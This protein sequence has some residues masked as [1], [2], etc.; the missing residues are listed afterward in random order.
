MIGSLRLRLM[1]AVAA[2]M[3]VVA[4]LDAWTTFRAAED[5]ARIVQER[6][7]VG[8]A[9]FIGEQVHL[10]E[11]VVQADIPPAALELFASPSRDHVFYRIASADHQTLAGYFDL[12]EP[13]QRL[14]GESVQ[15]YDTALRDRQVHAVAFEQPVFSAPQKGPVLIQIGQ[16]LDGR[17]A[18]AREIWAASI[19]GHVALLLLGVVV[20][21]FAMRLWLRPLL[22]LRD[23]FARHAP[24]ALVPLDA[25]RTPDELQPLVKVVNEYVGRLDAHMSAHE[26]FIADASHQLRTPLTV[27]NT[28]VSYAL[29]ARDGRASDMALAAIRQSVQ[30]GIR[31]VNQ[32]L[33]VDRVRARRPAALPEVDLVQTVA[34]VLDAHATHAQQ[35]GIDLGLEGG[36]ATL[37]V[38]ADPVLLFEMIS[39]LVDNAVRY[40][41]HG[42]TV[43]AKVTSRGGETLVEVVDDG[44]GIPVEARELVFQRFHRL[45]NSR[46][47]GSGLGLSIVRD[48]AGHCGAQVELDA[49]AQ[50]RGLLA[51]VRFPA[52]HDVAGAG[53]PVLLASSSG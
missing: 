5:T 13:G 43:T 11:G 33:T 16:T 38:R 20:L 14:P 29:Q 6:M 41:Q 28:Q 9:R 40:T 48:V 34:A 50:H 39:N 3:A 35:R 44:P 47:D 32:L 25:S 52:C 24:G 2:P 21:W 53:A 36:D 15:F 17:R 30:H 22:E 18:L 51:R 46:S 26:R 49:P 4:A 12:A 19:G 45:D 31:L 27:L 42:G 7:L 23:Q 1:V 10:E 8:A 37:V